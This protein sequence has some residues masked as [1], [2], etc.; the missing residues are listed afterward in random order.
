MQE[1]VLPLSQRV[2]L[3]TVMQEKQTLLGRLQQA[4]ASS[5]PAQT[6]A[7]GPTEIRVVAD[8]SAL[9]EVDTSALAMLVALDRQV[10]QLTRQP[11]CIRSA[12]ENLRSLA[13][14]TS[15]SSVVH[16]E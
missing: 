2:V 3:A 5:S 10:R 12:P 4:L 13:R 8:L 16:W 14:L 11:L 6:A 7:G 9:Q 1:L 15:L